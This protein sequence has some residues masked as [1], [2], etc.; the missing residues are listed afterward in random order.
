MG[1]SVERWLGAR[2]PRPTVDCV[3]PSNTHVVARLWSN[4]STGDY[5]AAA[6][7]LHPDLTVIWPTSRERYNT[8]TEYLTVNKAFGDDWTFT[9]LYLAETGEDSVVSITKVASPTFPD[10][11]YATSVIDLRDGVITA[12]QTY[13]ATQDTQPQWREGLSHLLSRCRRI[14]R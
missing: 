2:L 6:H 8:R 10:S 4:F 9:V 12:M 3:Q 14:L 5:D 1:P 13:W 7:L 11:Y